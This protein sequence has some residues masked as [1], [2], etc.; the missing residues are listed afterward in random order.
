MMKD[1]IIHKPIY[2]K[3]DR[4]TAVVMKYIFN[5]FVESRLFIHILIVDI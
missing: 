4:N 2:D 5:D 1:Q 3:V